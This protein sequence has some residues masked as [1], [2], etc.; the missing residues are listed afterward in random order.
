VAKPFAKLFSGLN[1]DQG[2]LVGL[3]QSL[4]TRLISQKHLQ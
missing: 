1:V 3:S 2:D 4:Q